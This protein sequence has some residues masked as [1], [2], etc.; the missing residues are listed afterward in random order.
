[1]STV[2]AYDDAT[3]CWDLISANRKSETKRNQLL[4][5][6]RLGNL[7]A[8]QRLLSLA[9]HLDTETHTFLNQYVPGMYIVRACM[10]GSKSDMNCFVENKAAKQTTQTLKVN[11]ETQLDK[12]STSPSSLLLLLLSIVAHNN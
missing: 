7:N 2:E 12:V 4:T 1:M 9:M 10:S 5:F 6:S 11:R 3:Y 8:P